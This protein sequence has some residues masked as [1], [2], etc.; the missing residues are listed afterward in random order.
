VAL[1][2]IAER[3][4]AE[5][6]R[7]A[8]RA[9]RELAALWRSVDRDRIAA[10][11]RSLLPQALVLLSAAQMTAASAADLYVTDAATDQQAQAEPAGLVEPG[12]FGGIASDGRPLASLLY[13][14]AIAA[15]Q[16][17]AG[18]VSPARAMTAGG[19]TLD[20]IGRTQV[21]DAG[22]TADGV[23][24]ASRPQLAGYV[25]V[26][27][28]KTCSRCLILAGKRYRWN[29]GFRRH[30]RCDCRHVPVAELRQAE[31]VSPR[32]A[33]DGLSHAEQ[34]ATFGKAGAQAIRDGAEMSQVVNARR[35]IYTADGRLFTREAAGRRP[36]VM[37]EQIFRDAR[38]RDDAVRLLRQHGYITAAP[39]RQAVTR[40][41]AITIRPPRLV[42][43]PVTQHVVTRGRDLLAAETARLNA[44]PANVQLFRQRMAQANYDVVLADVGKLQGFDGLPQVGTK[45][46]LDAAVGSGWTELWRGVV[47]SGLSTPADIN[48]RLRAGAYEPGRGLYGNGWYFSERRITAENFRFREPKTNFPAGGG[49][50]FEL[51]D[52]EDGD[53]APDGLVRMA[54]SPQARVIDYDDLV[55]LRDRWQASQR[56]GTPASLAFSDP[57]RLA[58]ALGYDAVRIGGHHGDGGYYPGWEDSDDL[59][60]AIQI[61]VLNRTAMLIQRAEDKP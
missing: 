42:P 28:G 5:Q 11:W 29:A 17:I 22:R 31:V 48:G 54:L 37:P 53:D 4:A 41:P 43:P 30:P 40:P 13:Q 61:V 49:A 23:A 18:G 14:P 7:L 24:L 32:K 15:L 27:V 44:S 12:A 34:D 6:V 51:S 8:K 45:A 46:E 59:G 10:S 21:A 55:K 56:S 35:G 33:F 36:R 2:Q 26:V 9:A 20:L 3:H 52:L 16:Q 60:G 47:G 39:A 57:G 25:R 38:D 1:E 19:F 50:D 58:T